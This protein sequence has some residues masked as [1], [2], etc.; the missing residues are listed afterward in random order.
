[1]YISFPALCIYIYGL[2]LQLYDDLGDK[3]D[4]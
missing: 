1:M 3:I 4:P 2:E